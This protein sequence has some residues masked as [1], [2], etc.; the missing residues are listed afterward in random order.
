[1]VRRWTAQDR[2]E[3]AVLHRPQ[4]VGRLAPS[5]ACTSS[6]SA[7]C[8]LPRAA[9]LLAIFPNWLKVPL[10]HIQQTE[11]PRMLPSIDSKFWGIQTDI[12]LRKNM[13]RNFLDSGPCWVN[14]ALLKCCCIFKHFSL[15][16]KPFQH[17]LHLLTKINLMSGVSF[18]C[19][20]TPHNL[21]R[22]FF[23]GAPVK[24]IASG[25]AGL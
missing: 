19:F 21:G 22:R 8:F 5:P 10:T 14:C 1:M 18:A 2:G 3:E 23:W 15:H 6:C 25:A 4:A 24:S 20:L 12:W 13:W 7:L 9:P 17:C 11:Y 16:L